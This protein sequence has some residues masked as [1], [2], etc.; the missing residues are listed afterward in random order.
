MN[1]KL[2]S[3]SA[4]SIVRASTKNDE[5]NTKYCHFSFLKKIEAINNNTKKISG[6]NKK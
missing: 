2:G 3:N 5:N 4:L 6:K 1:P